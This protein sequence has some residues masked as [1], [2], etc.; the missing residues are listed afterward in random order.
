VFAR[1]HQRTVMATRTGAAVRSARVDLDGRRLRVLVCSARVLP[2]TACGSRFHVGRGARSCWTSQSALQ[3]SCPSCP[4]ARPASSSRYPCR[5]EGEPALHWDRYPVCRRAARSTV[6]T[7]DR[8]LEPTVLER[9]AMAGRVSRGEAWR[10]SRSPMSSA[11][12]SA[13]DWTLERSHPDARWI[14]LT[15]AHKRS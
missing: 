15:R 6:R 11:C 8:R 4:S 7:L 3:P 10:F 13:T 12:G 2:A 5:E 14:R 9:R 1:R